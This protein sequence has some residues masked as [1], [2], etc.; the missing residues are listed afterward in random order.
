MSAR[1]DEWKSHLKQDCDYSPSTRRNYAGDVAGFLTWYA[2]HHGAECDP[3]GVH[4]LDIVRYRDQKKATAKP[5]TINRLLISI[6][7][8]FDWHLAQGTINA[9]PALGVKGMQRGALA[10]RCISDK[11]EAALMRAAQKTGTPRDRTILKIFLHTG[12]RVSELCGLTIEN[13]VLTK[14][15]A[16]L[17]IWGKHR[18]YRE[19][20]LNSTAR[21]T[22]EAWIF[23]AQIQAGPLFP[24][25]KGGHLSPRAIGFIV[26]HYAEQANLKGVRPH[27]LRHRFAYRLAESTPIHRIAQ[28]LGHN[29]LQTT[30][31]YVQATQDDLAKDTEGIAWT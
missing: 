9:N 21:T 20:P 25:Q 31:R 19:V 26:G 6:R 22:L 12:L 16:H 11:E 10:P 14:N 24:S 15:N 30:M 18:R 28:I 4:V 8:F 27:D 13:T 23:H 2:A 7:A 17:R 29:N 1:F 3:A 5:A